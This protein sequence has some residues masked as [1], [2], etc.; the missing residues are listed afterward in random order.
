MAK[1]PAKR[2]KK[3][4]PRDLKARKNVKGGL[5]ATRMTIRGPIGFTQT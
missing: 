4:S 1:K 5:M 2:S 3:K